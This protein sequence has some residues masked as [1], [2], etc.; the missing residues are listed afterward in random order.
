[1]DKN[2]NG[3]K[4]DL[5]T[6][7]TI[8]IPYLFIHKISKI[9][10]FIVTIKNNMLERFSR[11]AQTRKMIIQAKL[12]LP[13][14]SRGRNPEKIDVPGMFRFVLKRRKRFPRKHRGSRRRSE[15]KTSLVGEFFFNIHE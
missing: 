7:F 6:I 4:M 1:M 5:F 9:A 3:S 14:R 11:D 13:T 2:E 8:S 15:I 12:G 10:I